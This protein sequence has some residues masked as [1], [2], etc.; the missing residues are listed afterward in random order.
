MPQL[1][2]LPHQEICPEG[3]VFEVEP[4]VTISVAL[5]NFSFISCEI[6]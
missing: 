3:A 2:F 5:R 6:L 1:I 4:G